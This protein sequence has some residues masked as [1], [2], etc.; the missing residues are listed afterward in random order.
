MTKKTRRTLLTA[1]ACLTVSTA[2]F[3]LAACNDPSDQTTTYTLSFDANGGSSVG[4]VTIEEGKA[5]TLPTTEKTNYAFCGWYFDNGTFNDVANGTTLK[6]LSAKSDLTVYA[7]W[8]ELDLTKDGVYGATLDVTITDSIVLDTAPDGF[9]PTFES[10]L[11]QDESGI[12]I[13]NGKKYLDLV[14]YGSEAFGYFQQGM[15]YQVTYNGIP[16][17][18]Y[19][20]YVNSMDMA[21]TE[22]RRQ[23]RLPI[24]NDAESVTISVKELEV[25]DNIYATIDCATYDVTVKISDVTY[26][27]YAENNDNLA[28]GIYTVD[29]H[30]LSVKDG[31]VSMNENFNDVRAY[32]SVENG[33]MK[34]YKTFQSYMGMTG[35][36]GKE[37]YFHL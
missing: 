8:E 5:V 7:K 9:A 31:T 15:R 29:T 32:I 36:T 27:A 33:N 3:G 10:N 13:I 23:F 35:Q 19:N 12:S 24:E 34:M 28:D 26:K 37:A 16:L 22:G 30:A 6:Y 17:S 21:H 1:L 4:A 25:G 18:V 11:S 14:V 20:T 2:A